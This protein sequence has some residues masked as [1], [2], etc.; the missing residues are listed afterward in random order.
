ML[1]FVLLLHGVLSWEVVH[2]LC[3]I[4]NKCP[5]GE[6][7]AAGRFGDKEMLSWL[8]GPGSCVASSQEEHLYSAKDLPCF[9]IA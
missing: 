3:G 4:T 5:V 9:Q 6:Q 7:R 8:K 2:H 1:L